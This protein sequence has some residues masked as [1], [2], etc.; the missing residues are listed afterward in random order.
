MEQRCELATTTAVEQLAT[1]RCGWQSGLEP[2]MG[3]DSAAATATA[4]GLAELGTVGDK[5][6]VIGRAVEELWQCD[7]G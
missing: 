2:R 5:H 6:V 4:T 1:G 3:G 7:G